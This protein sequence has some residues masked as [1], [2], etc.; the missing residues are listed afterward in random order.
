[1]NERPKSRVRKAGPIERPGP[2]II[3]K[4][5]EDSAGRKRFRGN[6]ED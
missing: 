4:S 5:G 6:L 2:S 1:M 3:I